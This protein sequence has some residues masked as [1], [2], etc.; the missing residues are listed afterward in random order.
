MKR[1]FRY[2]LPVM[3]CALS[4]VFLTGCFGGAPSLPGRILGYVTADP[5]AKDL[6]PG[7]R[8]KMKLVEGSRLEVIPAPPTGGLV[9]A[10]V[11]AGGKTTWTDDRGYFELSLSPGTYTVYIAHPRY[12]PLTIRGV[13]VRS[14][15]DT[16]VNGGYPRIGAFYYLFVG[17][18]N[19]DPYEIYNPG[20]EGSPDLSYAVADA[21][22]M[23]KTLYQN[24]YYAGIADANILK[25]QEATK[26]KIKAAIDAIAA[27]M[28]P[29]DHFLMFFSGHGGQ[30]TNIPGEEDEFIAPS[31]A[32]SDPSRIITDDELTSWVAKIPG[33]NKVF[34]FDSCYS[35]GM[36]KYLPFF[37]GKKAKRGFTAL[38]RDLNQAG[39][40]VITASN[41]TEVSNEYSGLDH[42]VFS[43]FFCE[44]IAK[45]AGYPADSNLDGIIT[46]QEAFNYAKPRV[47]NYTYDPRTGEVQTPQIWPETGA[48]RPIYRVP[49]ADFVKLPQ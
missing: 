43:Y 32:T 9:G 7:A 33:Q 20:T 29:Q 14:G 45:T 22:L 5:N 30:T 15:A 42:G 28:Q 17:I 2:L 46:A 38:A 40:V 16:W 4:F 6:P 47:M 23:W 8:P 24:N 12:Q 21:E 48:N 19:Y 37:Q 49:P 35:G 41:D 25:D 31:D 18:N 27:K 36:Y 34:I 39:Y 11:T 3:L 10:T 13:V 1:I 44:G 26:A